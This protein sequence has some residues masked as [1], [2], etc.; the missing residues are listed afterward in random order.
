[1]PNTPFACPYKCLLSCDAERAN[2][3]IAVALLNAA[4]GHFENAFAMC[5][6]NAFRIDKIVT[7]KA[8]IEELVQSAVPCLA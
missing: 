3:C 4:R 6:Q 2:Y 8:L 1:M 5:G 7:V